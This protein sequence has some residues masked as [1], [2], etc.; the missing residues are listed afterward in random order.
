MKMFDLYA[1]FI[2]LAIQVL[3]RTFQ[4]KTG[5]K[6]RKFIV[7]RGVLWAF[8]ESRGPWKEVLLTRTWVF[9]VDYLLYSRDQGLEYSTEGNMGASFCLGILLCKVTFSHLLSFLGKQSRHDVCIPEPNISSL[10]QW[11]FS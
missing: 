2:D 5:C 7:L 9:E 6:Y 10:V 3:L 1:C 11:N 4:V 8:L